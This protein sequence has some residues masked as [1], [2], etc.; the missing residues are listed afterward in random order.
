MPPANHAKA[1]VFEIFCF[2]IVQE[3]IAMDRNGFT[4]IVPSPKVQKK[5][6]DHKHKVTFVLVNWQFPISLSVGLFVPWIVHIKKKMMNR[7]RFEIEVLFRKENNGRKG[8][9]TMKLS[10]IIFLLGLR[11]F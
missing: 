5:K 9:L 7:P 2:F 8:I 4:E 6:A 10:S 11:K 1:V 3:G